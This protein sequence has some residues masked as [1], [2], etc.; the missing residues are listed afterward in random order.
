MQCI[1]HENRVLAEEV[2]VFVVD[3]SNEIGGHGDAPHSSIGRARRLQ[4]QS[5]NDQNTKMI[6]CV[7]NHT[8]EVMFIDEIGR[9]AEVLAAE[10]CKQRGVRIVASA[11]GDLLQIFSNPQLNA[12][13]GGVTVVT[14][15]DAKAKSVADSA[16]NQRL[17]KLCTQRSGSPIFDVVVELKRGRFDEWSVVK[18]VGAAIDSLIATHRYRREVRLRNPSTGE[19]SIETVDG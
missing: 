16:G 4:V 1:A 7:Q 18:D 19:F 2:N 6:E 3:T 11:H 8:P 17:Q 5:L 15:G 13:V 14:V 9:K 12:L 10:T